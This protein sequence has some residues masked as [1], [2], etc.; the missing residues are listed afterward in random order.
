MIVKRHQPL[1]FFFLVSDAI[2]IIISF[3]LAYF[4]RFFTFL[5][6]PKG[7]P[8]FGYYL[9]SIFL[10]L[11]IH[12]IVFHFQ[13][14]YKIKLKRPRSEDLFTIFINIII[15]NLVALGFLSYLRS[16]RL[17]KFEISHLFLLVYAV[18]G[19]FFIF[20][21]RG[22]VWNTIRAAYRKNYKR[23]TLVIGAGETGQMIAE[24]IKKYEDLGYKF[25]GFVDDEKGGEDILGK[26]NQ[27]SKIV[28][29]MNIKEIFIALPLHLYDKFIDI[30]KIAN[31][32]IVELRLVPDMLQ[33]L[34]LKTGIDKF[35][36]IPVINLMDIPLMG[37]KS[38]L[39]RIIDIII[40]FVC[41][42][43][44]IPVFLLTALLIKLTSK[45]KIIY[46]QERVGLDG[47]QFKIYKFRTM[48]EDA[49]R[50][51]GPVWAADDDPRITPIG[52]ILR[53]L[54]ID[55]FPQL[56]NVL[57]GDMSLVGPRPERPYFVESFKKYFPHYMLRH[58]VKSGM[59]GW[60]QAHGLR[61]NT[62]LDKRLEYDLYYIENW[63]LMLDF[64]ILWMTFWKGFID[65]KTT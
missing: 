17:T 18:L 12:I 31:E 38:V 50:Q 11:F 32:N 43:I 46:K 49:E 59:T 37:W 65:K 27:L 36:G 22:F 1:N 40:S 39:K 44:L 51:T 10:F 47:K 54:S 57:K 33:Y 48:I 26:T 60:A 6:A 7:I 16:Y 55:E 35:E 9:N 21:S 45:G 25:V 3:I 2:S 5:P 28:K 62:P 63:S 15:T 8:E 41:L 24:K 34:T 61:G 58:K 14:F 20:I 29:E 4:V 42:I 19:F 52:K 23:N 30:I 56:Y 53:K 64:K 13:R